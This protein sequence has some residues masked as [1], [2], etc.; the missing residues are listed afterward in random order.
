MKRSWI[1]IVVLAL[2]IGGVLVAKS[3]QSRPVPPASSSASA[4]APEEQA[5]VLLFADPKEA[6]QSCGCGEIFRAVR[7]ASTQGVRTREIDPERERELVRRYRVTVEPTVIFVD[8]TGRETSRR[9]GESGNT[10][11]ALRDDL[12][13]LAGAFP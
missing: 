6:E 7:A 8:S 5:Q 3:L 9:E 10:I 13:R 2:L 11:S 4:A 1:G 12:A